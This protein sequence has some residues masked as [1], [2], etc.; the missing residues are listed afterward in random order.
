MSIL[1]VI[2]DHYTVPLL[3]QNPD[4]IFVFGDNLLRKGKGG[5]AVIRDEINS[6]GIVTKRKPTMELDAFFSDKIEELEAMTRDLERL[7]ILSMTNEVVFPVGGI[8]T[9]LAKLKEFSPL[10][11]TELNRLL[12]F[13]F[14]YKNP[15]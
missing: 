10:I 14:G 9:G 11:W 5:Q 15:V 1:T 7:F 13:Y 12:E 2:N 3:R 4:K 8:G 6:F